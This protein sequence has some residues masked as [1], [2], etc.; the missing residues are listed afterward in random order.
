LLSGEVVAKTPEQ[1][2]RSRYT[3]FSLG[4][5]GQYLLDTWFPATAKGLTVESL[6]KKNVEWIKL[7]VLSKNQKGDNASVV[8]NAFFHTRD[9]NDIQVMHETSIFKRMSGRWFYVGGEVS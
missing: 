9:S 7:E 8:F 3:A 1:L 6:S 4:N 5:H 2:M